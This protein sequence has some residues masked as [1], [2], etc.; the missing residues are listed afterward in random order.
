VREV[1]I[2]ARAWG[3]GRVVIV[4]IPIAREGSMRVFVVEDD[5][6]LGEFFVE[7]LTLWGYEV[8]RAPDTIDALERI[9]SFQP[10]VVISEARMPKLGGVDLLRVLR[11]CPFAPKCILINGDVSFEERDAALHLGALDFMEKPLDFEKLRADLEGCQCGAP[12]TISS[13]PSSLVLLFG[14]TLTYATSFVVGV[15]PPHP[16]SFLGHPLPRGERVVARWKD[17][18][19]IV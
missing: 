12:G 18:N 17:Q 5:V 10:A 11:R 14:T 7:L 2:V 19:R 15:E 4:T 1:T 9:P 13:I 8:Q 6:Q 16:P 3:A